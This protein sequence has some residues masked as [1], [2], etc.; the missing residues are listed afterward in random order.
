MICHLK[1]EDEPNKVSEG[2]RTAIKENIVNLML[3]SPEQIQKQVNLHLSWS[4]GPAVK[5][6][7]DQ[8]VF[9]LPLAKRCHQYHRKRRF[10]SK[11][12]QPAD[13]DGEPLPKWRFPHH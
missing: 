10:P 1:V 5:T 7:S 6:C 11:M 9:V 8:F 13:R 3:S 12:A 2:D 4:Q